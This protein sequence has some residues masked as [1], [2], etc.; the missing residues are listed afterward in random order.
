MKLGDRVRK[1]NLYG[2]VCGLIGSK[3]RVWGDDDNYYCEEGWE[4]VTEES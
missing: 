4:L 2:Y 1:G 3:V